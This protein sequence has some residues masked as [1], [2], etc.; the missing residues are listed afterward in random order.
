VS[1][2][3]LARIYNPINLLRIRGNLSASEYSLAEVFALLGYYTA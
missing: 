2:W 1:S 3:L